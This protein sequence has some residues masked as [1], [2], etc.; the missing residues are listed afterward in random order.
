LA[1]IADAAEVLLAPSTLG[2]LRSAVDVEPAA[3]VEIGDERETAWRLA[4]VHADAA[5]APRRLDLPL[6]GRDWELAQLHHAFERATHGRTSYLFTLL[7][8]GGIGK[9]RLAREFTEALAGTA[10]VLSGRCPSYGAGITFWPLA[11]IVREA[12]GDTTRSAIVSLIASEPDAD[13]IA[14][15]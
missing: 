3:E 9:S 10:T 6:V 2:A 12:A 14:A 1:Q 8:P 11:E 4:G 5:V 15:R 13:G 7:G